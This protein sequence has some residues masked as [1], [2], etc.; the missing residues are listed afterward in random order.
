VTGDGLLAGRGIRGPSVCGGQGAEDV[1]GGESNLDA[2]HRLGGDG[3]CDTLVELMR[4]MQMLLVLLVA[5][6]HY[7]W[8]H[9]PLRLRL[10]L[11]LVLLQV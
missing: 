6:H 11:R 9:L 10:R 1:A 4:V 2:L 3:L 7:R 8:W 5:T